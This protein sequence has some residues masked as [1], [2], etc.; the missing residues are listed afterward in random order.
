MGEERKRKRREGCPD[1][2]NAVLHAVCGIVIKKIN[3][4]QTRVSQQEK[5]YL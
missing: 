2:D 3:D 5:V 4:K 1:E